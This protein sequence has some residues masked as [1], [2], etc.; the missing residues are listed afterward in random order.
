MGG[1]G[2]GSCKIFG[3][4]SPKHQVTFTLYSALF[5][6][7]FKRFRTFKTCG[8]LEE[9]ILNKAGAADSELWLLFHPW[10]IESHV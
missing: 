7:R 10:V 4:H 2:G 1:G 9:V 6:K 5:L 8:K 3:D